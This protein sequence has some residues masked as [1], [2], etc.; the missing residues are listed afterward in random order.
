MNPGTDGTAEAKQ[1]CCDVYNHHPTN[2]AQHHNKKR[3]LPYFDEVQ[4]KKNIIMRD[5]P[6]VFKF[7]NEKLLRTG[8]GINNCLIAV[9][10]HLVIP[11]ITHKKATMISKPRF[12]LNT[13]LTISKSCNSFSLLNII[14]FP[15]TIRKGLWQFKST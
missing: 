5:V 8:N 6:K 15:C 4:R 2:A 9:F 10:Q 1:H 14:L 13:K 7:L 3:L 11:R 12:Y